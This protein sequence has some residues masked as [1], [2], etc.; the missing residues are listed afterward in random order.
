MVLTGSTFFLSS[1]TE[2]RG[3]GL[4]RA[5]LESL[6]ARLAI[7]WRCWLSCRLNILWQLSQPLAPASRLKLTFL[8]SWISIQGG[9]YGTVLLPNR[10]IITC[11]LF[12]RPHAGQNSK[13][14]KQPGNPDCIRRYGSHRHYSGVNHHSLPDDFSKLNSLLAWSYNLTAIQQ[15]AYFGRDD[16]RWLS[17]IKFKP[18]K[19]TDAGSIPVTR[20]TKIRIKTLD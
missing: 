14:I 9:N 15:P 4:P 17:W 5:R 16:G 12:G 8:P 2:S 7:A 11:G 19:L 1:F 3:A 18:S 20:T 10:R 6:C 13:N